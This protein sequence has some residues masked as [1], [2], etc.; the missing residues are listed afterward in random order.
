MQYLTCALFSV[1]VDWDNVPNQTPP[2]L[3]PYLPSTTKGEAGMHSDYNVRE[4]E[5]GSNKHY[6][7]TW[8][9]SFRCHLR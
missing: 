4:R 9:T 7:I 1:G 2:T 6:L 5:L 3:L 8:L